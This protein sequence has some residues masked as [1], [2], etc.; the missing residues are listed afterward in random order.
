MAQQ[1]NNSMEIIGRDE[2]NTKNITGLL[3]HTPNQI[4]Y[5]GGE[6]EWISSVKGSHITRGESI[7]VSKNNDRD[8]NSLMGTSSNTPVEEFINY[9]D[10]KDI[11]GYASTR[12]D[13]IDLIYEHKDNT[14]TVENA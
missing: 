8:I 2:L 12:Q 7:S 4:K 5:P 1:N 6:Y 13:I 9:I 14:T 10:D 3:V 11:I